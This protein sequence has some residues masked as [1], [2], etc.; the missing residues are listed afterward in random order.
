MWVCDRLVRGLHPERADVQLRALTVHAARTPEREESG[1]PALGVSRGEGA[2][3]L[4]ERAKHTPR[5]VGV[6]V[7][8][9]NAAV[10]T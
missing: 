2:V 10:I 4:S 1:R 8:L 5:A 6:P 3:Q 7:H 9:R